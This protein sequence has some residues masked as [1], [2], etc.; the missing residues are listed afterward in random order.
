MDYHRIETVFRDLALE[1]G[2]KR[3]EIYNSDDFGVE[4]KDD[5]SP[6]T[7]A[8]KAADEIIRAGL[9]ASFPDILTVTEENSASHVHSAQTFIIVDPLDGTKEF[10]K[11]RGDFTVNIALVEDG[12]PTR[13]V[14]FAPAKERLFYTNAAG[15]SVEESGA[16]SVGCLLYTSD[17]AD[18]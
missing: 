14:V 4:T 12:V 9:D 17:A 8:D 15:A 13:G 18:E 2:A 1:A 10:V 16:Q 6:V 5:A 7:K 11:R 3:L